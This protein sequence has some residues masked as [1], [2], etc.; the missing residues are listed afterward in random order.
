MMSSE[1][2]D[3]IEQ[4]TARLRPGTWG[5]KDR[6]R[7]LERPSDVYRVSGSRSNR[8]ALCLWLIPN[9][10]TGFDKIGSHTSSNIHPIS[11]DTRS[12]GPSVRLS[13]LIF[14]APHYRGIIALD[15]PI[16]APIFQCLLLRS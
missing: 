3:L 14:L 4:H 6:T 11:R 15:A 10:Q 8:I 2:N 9:A 12:A 13:C 1:P 5:Q 7:F 16:L